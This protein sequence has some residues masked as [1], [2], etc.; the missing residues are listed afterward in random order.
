MKTLGMIGG[1][2]PDSTID[3]YRLII[4]A[5][6]ERRPDGSY[7]PIIINSVNLKEMVDLLEANNLPGLVAR[8]VAEVGK[9]A[10]AG[11]ELGI[12]TSNTPHIVFDDV[13]R[14]CPIPLIS[15]VEATCDAAATMGL[16]K[17]GL[18]GSRYTMQARFYPDVFSRRGITLISP[19]ADEQ[20]YIHNRYMSELVNGIFRAETRDGLLQIVDRMKQQDHID[21]LILGGTELPLILRDVPDRGIPF[22]DTTRIHVNA[23]MAQLGV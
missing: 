18:V 17:L 10:K 14:Q 6:R 15:I 19:H 7:P 11:A 2:G 20:A 16:R 22:L 4:A 13:A 12:L 8:L 1:V 21:G 23:V 5:Y 3:Y 9:L